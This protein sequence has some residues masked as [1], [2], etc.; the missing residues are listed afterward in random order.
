MPH[1]PSVS[2]RTIDTHSCHEAGDTI[3]SAT[4]DNHVSTGCHQGENWIQPPIADKT[5]R[6]P[7]GTAIATA[8]TLR[9]SGWK[10]SR[11]NALG[12][13]QKTM[14]TSRNAYRP[15]RNVPASPAAQRAYPYAPPFAIAA[16]RIGS[17]EKKPANGKMPTSA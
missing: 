12:S 4:V 9:C 10:C 13:P 1:R 7:T 8:T 6:T 17:F 14:K 3:G 5:A 2:D 11:T 16:A 15:V